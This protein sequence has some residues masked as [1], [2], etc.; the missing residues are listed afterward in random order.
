MSKKPANHKLC[1]AADR[2]A[3]DKQADANLATQFVGNSKGEEDKKNA[4]W[5]CER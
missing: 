1:D 5:C 3:N 4:R 2:I